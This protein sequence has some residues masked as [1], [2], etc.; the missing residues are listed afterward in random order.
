MKQRAPLAALQLL[1]LLS[2][3]A[4]RAQIATYPVR[5]K[6]ISQADGRPIANASLRILSL[7]DRKPLQETTSG[8]DGL[9]A[10]ADLRAGHYELQG[11]APGFLTT[12]YEQHQGF[13]TAIVT[14][15]TVSAAALVLELVPRAFLSGVVNDTSGEPVSA[16]HLLLSHTGSDRSMGSEPIREAATND[17][18]Q[19]EFPDLAPG[20]YLLAVQAQPWYA[21]NTTRVDTNPVGISGPSDPGLH[22]AYPITYYPGVTDPLQ[23]SPLTLNAGDN[24]AD[25]RLGSVPAIDL[26]LPDRAP[27]PPPPGAMTSELV[28]RQP[29]R[30]L[31]ANVFGRLIPIQAPANMVEGGQVLSGLAPGDYL[32]NAETAPSRGRPN[33]TPI[34][35]SQSGGMDLPAQAAVHLRLILSLPDSSISNDRSTLELVAGN[36]SGSQPNAIPG[37][38]NARGEFE[39]T[40]PPGDYEV[41]VTVDAHPAAIRQVLAGTT[42]VAFSPLHIVA[43]GSAETVLAYTVTAVPATITLYGVAQKEGAPCHGAFIL[44]VPASELQ[45]PRD[46]RL[47]QSDLDGS[48]DLANVAPGSYLLFAIEDGWKLHWLEDGALTPYVS[49]A[50]RLQIPGSPRDQHLQTPVPVQPRL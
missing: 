8:A 41:R 4:A 12:E 23:A 44:L 30:Q 7:P 19:Y 32:M 13:S 33:L 35:L 2:P 36:G 29:G 15:S 5:G 45:S 28:R 49:G 18:G 34:H 1:F 26:T 43:R 10:F 3:L 46:W 6:V 42:A 25:L 17:L 37:A 50:Q 47:Q 21:S 38:R 9:F 40:V 27:P 22:V 31:F 20:P 11:E 39:L 48:F 14:G 16:A 24:S